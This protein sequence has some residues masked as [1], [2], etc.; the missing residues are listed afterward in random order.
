MISI[1]YPPENSIACG[2]PNGTHMLPG[3]SSDRR[4]IAWYSSIRGRASSVYGRLA[5]CACSFRTGFSPSSRFLVHTPVR[6]GR[7]GAAPV[8]A[9]AASTL[10]P[11]AATASSTQETEDRGSKRIENIPRRYWKEA[12]VGRR[13]R[14]STIPIM[15]PAN[16][17]RLHRQQAAVP[18]RRAVEPDEAGPGPEPVRHA[19]DHRHTGARLEGSDQLER[20]ET[21]ARYEQRVGL[22][23]ARKDAGAELEQIVLRHV[24]DFHDGF[25]AHAGD[26]ERLEA[27]LDQKRAQPVVDLVVVRSR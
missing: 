12:I 5:D 10:A 27:V 4:A 13:V 22:R 1:G 15:A 9:N 18:G 2:M 16:R 3:F 20:T 6:S 14:S 24:V 25:D 11:A 8:W 23:C 26:D 19:R 7:S 17:G 21:A